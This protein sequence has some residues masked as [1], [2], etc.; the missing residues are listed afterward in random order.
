LNG[1]STNLKGNWKNIFKIIS[2]TIKYDLTTLSKV[3]VVRNRITNLILKHFFDITYVLNFQMR[4]TTSLY[5]LL[6]KTFPTI[7][8]KNPIWTS[9]HLSNLALKT[10]T[11]YFF[12]KSCTITH[13]QTNQLDN[14]CNST[15]TSC[16]L[17]LLHTI[18]TK[19]KCKA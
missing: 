19:H 8:T 3:L 7:K 6:F 4:N 10:Y 5:N 16:I 17:H 1:D 15:I 11:P 13:N 18:K 14:L 12:T 9:F 2:H